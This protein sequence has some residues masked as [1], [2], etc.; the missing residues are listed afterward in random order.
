MAAT[1]KRAARCGDADELHHLAKV[2]QLSVS[3]IRLPT[4]LG[5]GLWVNGYTPFS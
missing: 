3:Q 5:T 1:E 4:C 2:W